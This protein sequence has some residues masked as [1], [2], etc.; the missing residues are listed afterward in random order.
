MATNVLGGV[1]MVKDMFIFS[2]KCTGREI[3]KTHDEFAKDLKKLRFKTRVSVWKYIKDPDA[4]GN[5]DKAEGEDMSGPQAEST[6]YEN[7]ISQ[8]PKINSQIANGF[9]EQIAT[10]TMLVTFKLVNFRMTPLSWEVLGKGLRNA[11]NL[12]H[13]TCNACNLYQDNNLGNLI[14][15]MQQNTE[16]WKRWV[17]KSKE[18]DRLAQEE[19][20]LGKTQAVDNLNTSTVSKKSSATHKEPFVYNYKPAAPRQQG[21]ET[22]R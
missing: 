9:A 10:S 13:F 12:R 1:D 4:K 20:F 14:N 19:G 18:E 15:G 6:N 8:N 17:K 11:K 21:K 22:N 3:Q 2:D 16:S 5:T 7:I